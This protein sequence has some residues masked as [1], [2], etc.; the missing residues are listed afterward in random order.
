MRIGQ[1]SGSEVGLRVTLILGLCVPSWLLDDEI[2]AH[3]VIS[4]LWSIS[5]I[6]IRDFCLGLT[7]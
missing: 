4:L 5:G 1:N 2:G 7:A 3:L 6:P